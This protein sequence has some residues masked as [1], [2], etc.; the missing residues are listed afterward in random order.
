M[1]F[2][3]SFFV[4]GVMTFFKFNQC[5]WQQ[6][7]LNVLNIFKSRNAISD[8]GIINSKK[9][10]SNT[11]INFLQ[12]TYYHRWQWIFFNNYLFS[13]HP[14]FPQSKYIMLLTL[15]GPGGGHI[16]STTIL[17]ELFNVVHEI[18]FISKILK[19]ILVPSTYKFPLLSQFHYSSLI[20]DIQVWDI[21]N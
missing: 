10:F 17:F 1:G 21:N 5:C 12:T 16:H 2:F 11:L 8:N 7:V 15:I 19:I 20:D 6:W 4:K 14:N 13:K 9:S 3:F 18:D